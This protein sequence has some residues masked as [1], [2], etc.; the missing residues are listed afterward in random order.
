MWEIALILLGIAAVDLA[1][2]A[3]PGPGFVTLT[4][5]AASSGRRAGLRCA[6]GLAV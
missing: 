3:S 2:A 4:R 6:L 1:G 5:V